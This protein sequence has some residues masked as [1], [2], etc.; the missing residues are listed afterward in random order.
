MDN[1]L[2]K[3]DADLQKA[4]NQFAPRT[5]LDLHHPRHADFQKSFEALRTNV[6][7]Y[8][9]PRRASHA[10]PASRTQCASHGAS[11]A[12]RIESAAQV[13]RDNLSDARVPSFSQLVQC[14]SVADEVL[15]EYSVGK[16][17]FGHTLSTFGAW[18]NIYLS[19]E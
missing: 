1:L 12:H 16:V 14:R 9:A 4:I 18:T 2:D 17:S 7:R 5:V 3:S 10:S 11:L 8:C 6:A 15:S 19:C 13:L